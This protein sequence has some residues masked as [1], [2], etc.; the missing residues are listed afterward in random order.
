MALIV[1]SEFPFP[2]DGGD[3][4]AASV[5]LRSLEDLGY[6]VDIL[7]FRKR[8]AMTR[9]YTCRGRLFEIDKAPR[10]RPFLLISA[11]ISDSSYLFK[12]FAPTARAR[13]ELHQLIQ[14]SS[15]SLVIL[16]HPY[17]MHLIDFGAVRPDLTLII[18]A[19]LLESKAFRHKARLL[20]SIAGCILRREART[21]EQ[22]EVACFALST[23]TF[24]YSCVETE[25]YKDLGGAN[26]RHVPFG[27]DIEQY[28]VRL[29]SHNRPFRIAFYGGFTWY[30]NADA[31]R[32]LLEDVW[33]AIRRR[34]S[35]VVLHIAGKSIPKWAFRH[36][37]ES[38]SIVGEVISIAEFIN[39]VDVIVAPIRIGGGV[40][41]KI[42]EAMALGRPVISTGVGLEG[43][44]AVVG[45]DVLVAETPEEFAIQTDLLLS[46]SE[47]WIHIATAGRKFIETSHDFRRV[48][49]GAIQRVLRDKDS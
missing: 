17:L 6:S 7:C 44:E 34:R 15:Y 10:L 23:E 38:V 49:K 16:V 26:G 1:T 28:K 45:R 21:S 46:S 40:R 22:E 25:W 33:P 36:V 18:S 24:F 3:K 13:I 42:L 4:L 32:Y 47:T 27:L 8:N 30:P 19:E 37:C 43:N 20:G 14:W 39:S 5:Y 12:R 11:I 41:V 29:R 31:L 35:D 2:A 9:K 48:T